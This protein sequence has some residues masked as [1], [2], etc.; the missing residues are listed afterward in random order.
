MSPVLL[1]HGSGKRAG[2]HLQD[3]GISSYFPFL[4]S[5]LPFFRPLFSFLFRHREGDKEKMAGEAH[6][7]RGAQGRPP[8]SNP[9]TV[10]SQT[11]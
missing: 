3:P 7:C 9:A 1:S 4:S 5:A 10:V 11:Q 2:Q 8:A 6:G